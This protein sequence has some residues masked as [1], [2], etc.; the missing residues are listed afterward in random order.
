MLPAFLRTPPPVFPV[1]PSDAPVRVL[2][3]GDFG[4]GSP[5]QKAVASTIAAYHAGQRFDFA[6]TL[7]D[8]FYSVGMESPPTCAGRH[9]G[10]GHLRPL[11]RR[12]LTRRLATTTGAI[13]TVQRRRS[14]TPRED[15]NLADAERLRHVLGGT[16]AVFCSSTR[17]ASPSSE[18]QLQ[19]LDAE[20]SRSQARWKVVY[21]HHPIDPGGAYEDRPD[22]IAK[23]LPIL[24]Q[25]RRRLHLAGTITTCRR[26]APEARSCASMSP[27]AAA[28]SL[29]DAPAGRPLA[30]RQPQRTVSPSSMPTPTACRSSS[31][32]TAARSCYEHVLTKRADGK[33]E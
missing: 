19:W 4:N 12:V 6:V 32:T 21:G 3:F 16:R 2:A 18:K 17:R 33:P 11:G 24:G 20:L 7:G 15:V 22:L 28:P 26:C 10:G 1:K 23:L 25:P 13:P 5:E 9:S 14:C 30:V 31:W 8:N 27:A 29:Y